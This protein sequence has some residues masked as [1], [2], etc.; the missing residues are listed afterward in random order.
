MSWMKSMIMELIF[1]KYFLIEFLIG[2]TDVYIAA[3][4]PYLSE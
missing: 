1:S 4:V 2:L 3:D